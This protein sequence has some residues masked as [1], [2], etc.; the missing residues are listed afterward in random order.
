MYAEQLAKY[1]QPTNH[2]RAASGS[3]DPLVAVWTG[4]GNFLDRLLRLSLSSICLLGFL[5]TFEALTR[6][7]VMNS[8]ML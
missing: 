3:F 8:V 7:V 2:M 1:V 6:C 4:V 5:G